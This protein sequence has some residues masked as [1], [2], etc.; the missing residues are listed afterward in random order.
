[1]RGALPPLE[2]SDL[3]EAGVLARDERAEHRRRDARHLEGRTV[4]EV[5]RGQGEAHVD[6]VHVARAELRQE[7]PRRARDDGIL[8]LP[9]ALPEEVFLVDDLRARPAELEVGEADL[10]LVLGAKPRGRAEERRRAG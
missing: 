1:Y 2:A 7:R 5:L 9:T 3:R 6:R 10:P 4:L 8:G